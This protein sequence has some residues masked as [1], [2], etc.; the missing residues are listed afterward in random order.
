MKSDI[1]F[2]ISSIATV[3]LTILASIVLFYFIKAGKNFFIL[4]KEIRG[5]FKESKE[6]IAELKERLENN[7]V[8][9]FLFPMKKPKKQTKKSH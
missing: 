2:F 1:F 9:R 8:F 6:I 3:T 7:L 4:S 5:D